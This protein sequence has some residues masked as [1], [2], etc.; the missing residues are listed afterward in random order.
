MSLSCRRCS[1]ELPNQNCVSAGF[2]FCQLLQLVSRHM[3]GSDRIGCFVASR[4]CRARDQADV[5]AAVSARQSRT[6]RRAGLDWMDY[7]VGR[8]RCGEWTVRSLGTGR[9]AVWLALKTNCSHT[10][11][12]VATRILSASRRCLI[13]LRRGQRLPGNGALLASPSRTTCR[14]L[15]QSSSNQ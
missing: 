12:G 9:L 10:D 8:G 5:A 4:R 13:G 7:G 15:L 6:L 11:V 2:T 3:I 1:P 14:Y